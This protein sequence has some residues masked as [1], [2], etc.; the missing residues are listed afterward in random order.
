VRVGREAQ[1]KVLAS[2]KALQV[3]AQS[4]DEAR[5]WIDR[6][7]L[8]VRCSLQSILIPGLKDWLDRARAG[9]PVAAD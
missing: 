9:S 4:G 1:N 3:T 6:G 7:A 2:G 5:E 8:M